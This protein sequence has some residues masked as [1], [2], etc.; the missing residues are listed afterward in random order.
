MLHAVPA[1]IDPAEVGTF[2]SELPGV[3]EIHDLHIWAMSTTDTALTA[4]VVLPAEDDID[5]F[6]RKACRGLHDQFGI[7]HATLQ[8]ER[9]Q[10]NGCPLAP[11]EV[12]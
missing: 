2:L 7:E 12:V 3:Q 6:L 1:G 5:A 4:H 8:V 9:N 11:T 10:D